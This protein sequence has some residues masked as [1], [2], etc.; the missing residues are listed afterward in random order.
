MMD[1]PQI[2]QP[3]RFLR[4]YEHSPLPVAI[5]KRGEV[6]TANAEEII[7]RLY[8]SQPGTAIQTPLVVF[9]RD[10][11]EGSPL[12]RFYRTCELLARRGVPWERYPG[13]GVYILSLGPRSLVP[14]E[15]LQLV[16]YDLS[17]QI[18]R[19]LEEERGEC[20]SGDYADSFRSSRSSPAP[21]K[22]RLVDITPDAQKTVLD[23]YMPAAMTKE[24]Y[25]GT[26]TWRVHCYGVLQ[27]D[28]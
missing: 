8:E 17:D 16:I 9:R 23:E 25:F 13:T 4:P 18:V 5:G 26:V 12:E 20:V 21:Y 11:R 14:G 24:R 7:V 10:S 22:Y 19:R 15:R 6:Y 27:E 28:K 2:H 3:V 1:I